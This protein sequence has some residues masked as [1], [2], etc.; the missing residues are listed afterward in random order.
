MARPTEVQVSHHGD[1]RFVIRLGPHEVAV[2]QPFENGGTDTAPNPTELFVGSY[3]ACVAFYARRFLHRHGLDESVTVDASWETENRPHRVSAIG[4]EVAAAVPP[5]LQA[6]FISVVRSCTVGNTLRDAPEV[7]L[8]VLSPSVRHSL[9]D[10]A[11]AD[12]GG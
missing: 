10:V 4:F 2:D 3:A 11:R 7:S 5:D 6:R 8:K 12:Q 1:D 9:N